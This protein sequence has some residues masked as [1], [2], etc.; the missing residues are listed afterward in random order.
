MRVLF[1]ARYRDATMWRKL[2]CLAQKPGIELLCITP[3][4]YQDELRTVRQ[5]SQSG[6]Y[7]LAVLPMLG[8][9]SDPHRALYRT[10][11]FHLPAFRPDIIHIEEEPDSLAALQMTVLRQ[12][13]APRA[14][15]LLHTWQ[16]IDRPRKWYVEWIKKINL[17]AADAVFCAN[18]AA[19]RILRVRGFTK[20]LPL[21]PAVGVDTTV[22]APCPEP[23]RTDGRFCVGYVGRFVAEKGIETLLQAASLLN[24]KQGAAE[25]EVHVLLIGAGPEQDR[26]AAQGTALGIADRLTFVAPLPPVELSTAYCRLDALVLPSRTTRVWEEQLGRVLLEAMACG[27]TVIGSNSGAIPEVIGDAGLLFPEGDAG[28]LAAQVQRLIQEPELAAQLRQRGL[29]RVHSHY[30]QQQLADA[31]YQFYAALAGIRNKPVEP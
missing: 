20:P 21:I 5:S 25:K 14:R 6:A 2:D 3:D 31:T 9:A 10:F 13:L 22:F 19:M 26:L 4:V 23:R 17:H 12:G 30:S 16:N 29:A 1:V 24:E 11:R 28:S 27:V 8:S 7:K 18:Q 15:L